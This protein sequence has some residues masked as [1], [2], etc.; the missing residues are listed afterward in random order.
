MDRDESWHVIAEQRRSLADLLAGLSAEQWQTPSLSA[1]WR[2][3]DVAAHVALA[4]Q[5]P[6]A[7]ATLAE[8]VRARGSFHRLNHDVAVR[9]A[10]RE[11]ERIVAE[12]REFAESH[13]LPRLTNYRNILFDILVHGQDIAIPLGIRREMPPAAAAAGATTVWAMGWPFRA[14]RRLHGYRVAATDVDWAAGDGA[15][16]RGPVDAVLLLLTGRAAAA[17]PRLTGP[18]AARLA[19]QLGQ[20]QAA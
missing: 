17:L 20:E 1:G 19:R 6:S 7:W 2:V 9:H 3:R 12:L 10:A 11:P 5:P 15:E 4:P 16:L 13:R 8:V 14:R 18:G